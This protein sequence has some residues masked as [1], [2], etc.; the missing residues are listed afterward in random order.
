M[1][2]KYKKKNVFVT[3]SFYF[4]QAQPRTWCRQEMQFLVKFTGG[5]KATTFQIRTNKLISGHFTE[6]GEKK[7]YYNKTMN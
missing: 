7:I 6:A 2:E 4:T 1:N 3:S 5:K